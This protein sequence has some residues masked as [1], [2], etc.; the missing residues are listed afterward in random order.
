VLFV[1]DHLVMRQGLINLTGTQQGIEVAG[2]A[3]NG[4]EATL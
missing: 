3:S 4:R 2:Q 1:D